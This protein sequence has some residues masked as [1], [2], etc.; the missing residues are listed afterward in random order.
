MERIV[1]DMVGEL[2]NT[3]GSV[4]TSASKAS[5]VSSN[6]SPF[7]FKAAFSEAEHT[8]I[9]EK[10]DNSLLRLQGAMQFLTTSASARSAA[11]VISSSSLK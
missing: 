4:V 10:F 8:S 11:S 3:G 6:S 2:V 7:A 9:Y 1:D 5:R